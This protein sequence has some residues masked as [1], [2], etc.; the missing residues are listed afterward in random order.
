MVGFG[1]ALALFIFSSALVSLRK[2]LKQTRSYYG[3]LLAHV[4]IGVFVV[5]VTLVKGY[6][7]EKDVKMQEGE[8]TELAGYDFKLEGVANAPGPNYRAARATVSVSRDGKPVAVLHPEK[9]LYTVQEMPMT[10]AAINTGL[11]RD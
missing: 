11:T 2:G 4:G 10:E 8:S 3:M 1:L 5:G 7:S 9:R 6:E